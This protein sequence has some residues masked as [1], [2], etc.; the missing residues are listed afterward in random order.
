MVARNV[1][2]I[3]DVD[4]TRQGLFLFNHFAA[5]DPAVML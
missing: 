5:G 3:G 2:R 4:T 1:R